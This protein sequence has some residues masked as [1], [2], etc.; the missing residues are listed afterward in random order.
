MQRFP[1]SHQ[2]NLPEPK[3]TR[4]VGNSGLH[5]LFLGR[6]TY[7]HDDGTV[8]VMLDNLVT[9]PRVPVSCRASGPDRD[10]SE[11][12]PKRSLVGLQFA[13]G[14][15]S[16]PFVTDV[17]RRP[18]RHLAPA[19]KGAIRRV[20]PSGMHHITHENG[21]VEVRWA[22]GSYM[23]IGANGEFSA[24]TADFNGQDREADDGNPFKVPEPPKRPTPK[25]APYELNL[26]L[27]DGSH[28]R[29][30]DG[31]WDATIPHNA[32]VN[33]GDNATFHVGG[34]ATF[35]VGGNA[36]IDAGGTVDVKAGGNATVKAAA[37]AK[38]EG[39]SVHVKATSSLKLQAGISGIAITP[40]SITLDA[41]ALLWQNSPATMFP[42][43]PMTPTFMFPVP[44]PS[45]FL[46]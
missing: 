12:P 40:G 16:Q 38:V 42:A 32:N 2:S 10:D 29:F 28:F 17:F 36:A 9:I 19:P 11:T 3:D 46:L 44:S 1:T 5:G 37:Q 8:D 13:H 26:K 20:Y 45:Q 34:N 14:N 24:P 18:Q 43:I 35:E 23:T 30:K 25:P 4:G 21:D 33:V 31:N 27:A 39:L 6:V 7:V 22:D 15:R 41:P